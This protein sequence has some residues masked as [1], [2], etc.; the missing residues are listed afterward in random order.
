ME[1]KRYLVVEKCSCFSNVQSERQG[2]LIKRQCRYGILCFQYTVIA[3][4]AGSH[5][6]EYTITKG[7]QSEHCNKP[8]TIFYRLQLQL[9]KLTNQTYLS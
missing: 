4:I 2:K 9:S 7:T 6:V 5:L 3:G 1:R 8:L